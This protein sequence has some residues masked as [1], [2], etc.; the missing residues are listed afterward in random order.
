MDYIYQK[1]KIVGRYDPF[2]HIYQKCKILVFFLP[3]P[4]N[5]WRHNGFPKRHSGAK[6]PQ[7]LTLVKWQKSDRILADQD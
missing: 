6:A 5:F 4:K 3:A 7:L 1:C 2:D